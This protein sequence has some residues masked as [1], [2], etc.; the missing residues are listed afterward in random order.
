[1]D[2]V[3]VVRGQCADLEP[4]VVEAHF[5]RLPPAYFERYSTSDISRHLRLLARLADGRQVD[6]EIRPLA[7]TIFEVLVVGIDHT[8]VVACIT[9][10]LAASGFDLEDVQV[11]TYLNTEAT[12]HGTP[13]PG[14]FVIVLRVSG[15]LRGR[16][17]SDWA[18]R[19]RGCLEVAFGHLAQG[20]LIE[21]QAA[22]QTLSVQAQASPT[23]SHPSS[24]RA[25]RH[26]GVAE[27]TILGG[28]FRLQRKL[29][30]GGMCEVYLATQISLSRTVA[31]KLFHHAGAGDDELLARFNQE[32]VVLAQFS[33]PRVV[34][35]LAAGTLPQEG[36]K[37]LGWM[38]MEYMAGGDLA[39]RLREQGSPPV[40]QATSWFRQALEGLLYAHR[41][42]I[43]HRDLKPHN[44]LLTAEG[45]LKISDFG[46]LKQAQ[47]PSL[48][49]TPRSTILGTPHYMSPEQALGESVDERSD[50][51]SLGSTFF[52]VFTGRVPFDR[53]SATALLVFIAQQDAP[54][55]TEVAPAAPRPLEVILGRMMA[56]RR[57]ERYQDA[58]VILE[59][60]ASYERRGLLEFAE[61]GTF[62]LPVAPMN[63]PGDETQDYHRPAGSEDPLD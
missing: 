6:V 26:S 8:G 56:R 47:H 36:G 13:E 57:E 24:I 12:L 63:T 54:R 42:H 7:S 25:V 29:A 33:C 48:G 37:V 34:Q 58:L 55:L 19:L 41:R 2:L 9:S 51:Y 17:P 32:A 28:D 20:N 18:A 31:I 27:G 52:H 35:I 4:S 38:A 5:R 30:D 40:R 49:L 60:L 45:H 22:A 44:L 21:A 16:L 10:A 62:A 61:S 14:Y 3:E 11:A 15:N 53:D 1:M 39:R 50:I 46:L 23:I 43:L 59:D